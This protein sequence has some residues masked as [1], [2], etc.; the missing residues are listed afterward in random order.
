ML[1]TSASLV[2][3]G[4]V[5]MRLY[6]EHIFSPKGKGEKKGNKIVEEKCVRE[7]EKDGMK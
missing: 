6:F 5:V 1:H 3:C 2:S 4:C 7:K